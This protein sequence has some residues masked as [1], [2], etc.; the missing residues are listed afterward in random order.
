[1]AEEK[2]VKGRALIGY[3]KF[4]KKKWGQ[5]GL[6]ECEHVLGYKFKEL[7]EDKWYPASHTDNLLKW[8]G[9]THG[10]EAVRNAGRAMV[11]EVGM[12]SFVARMAGFERILDK[13]MDEVR[14]SLNYGKLKVKK[15][16]GKAVVNLHDACPYLSNC[17]AWQ[18]IFEGTLI[19]TK[20][21]G[22][23]EKTGCVHKGQEACTYVITW[24]K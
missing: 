4:I 21:N 22:K 17:E 19:L 10:M 13:A 9:D 12:V 23:V 8:I 24:S 6:E 3:G 18:G 20:T 5:D 16:P 14:N 2:K 1:M 7:G 15:E 11:T